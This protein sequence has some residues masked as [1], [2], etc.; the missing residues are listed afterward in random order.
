MGTP[1][2]ASTYHPTMLSWGHGMWGVLPTNLSAPLWPYGTHTHHNILHGSKQEHLSHTRKECL[3]GPDL[4]DP[5]PQNC[6]R[7]M[8]YGRIHQRDR[9]TDHLDGVEGG[10]LGIQSQYFIKGRTTAPADRIW[11]PVELPPPGVGICST[12]HSGTGG[13]I[14]SIREGPTI[15][16]PTGTLPRGGVPNAW[17]GRH[18][19]PHQTD[20]DITPRSNPDRLGELDGTL[21]C[22]KINSCNCPGAIWVQVWVTCTDTQGRPCGD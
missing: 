13:G 9:G 16:L 1:K 17:T 4:P 12:C 11:W 18:H 20:Q 5:G 7:K 3:P 8:L 15:G 19:L 2:S 21:S 22:H 14:Q 6:H 10:I